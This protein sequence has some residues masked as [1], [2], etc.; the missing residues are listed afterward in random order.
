MAI[1]LNSIVSFSSTLETKYHDASRYS[2]GASLPKA[3]Q[4]TPLSVVSRSRKLVKERTFGHCLPVADSDQLAA[5][6]NISEEFDTAENSPTNDQLASLNPPDENFQLQ[7]KVDAESVSQT[8]ESSNG[9]IN[10]E[11]GSSSASPKAQ[12][13]T[14]GTSLTARERLK[15]A[16]AGSRYPQTRPSKPADMGSRVLEA[17]K[18]SDKGKKKSGLPEAPTNLFD[19]SK[20]GLSTGFTF[21]FPGGSDL[22]LIVL[23]FV[24][25]SSIMFATTF[26]VWKVGAIHFN[27]Y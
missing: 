13:A 19:D 26:I 4:F 20:R 9:S 6:N 21:Q 24:L 16:R 7:A 17:S 2:V 14:K 1:S 22:F 8:L 23:S 15:A 11:Q 3:S 18:Q 27:E 5:D 25:I 10:Q 12:S